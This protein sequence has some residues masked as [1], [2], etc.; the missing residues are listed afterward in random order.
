MGGIFSTPKPPPPPLLPA[1]PA[2][3]DD[4]ERKQRLEAM[5][6]RRRGR[7]GTIKTSPRGVLS[8]SVPVT[9][10]KKTLFGE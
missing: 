6:R 8:E 2:D 3:V 9:T 1:P 5:E 4:E 7:G 10:A